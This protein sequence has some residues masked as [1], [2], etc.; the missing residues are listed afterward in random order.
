MLRRDVKLAPGNPGLWYELGRLLVV[1]Q[2]YD[3]APDAFAKAA[4]LAPTDYRFRLMHALSLER[5]F[6]SSG[7]QAD[8]DAAVASLRKLEALNPASPDAKGILRR[9]LESRKA[10]EPTEP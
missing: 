9:L 8:F 3:Q 10:S 4:Q 5:R 1:T 7:E 2:Q 6:A